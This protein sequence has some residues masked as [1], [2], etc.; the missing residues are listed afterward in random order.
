MGSHVKANNYMIKL[1]AAD[2]TV[3]R[4]YP[5]YV[6]FETPDAVKLPVP[7]RTYLGI[8][9]ACAKV[10]HLSG[11]AEYI[12]RL[13]QDMEGGKILDP[14]GASAYMLEHAIFELQAYGFEITA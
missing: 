8:H 5:E 6:T 1:D 4:D 10:A 12:D 3:L 7:S 9:A 14:N 11:A 13:H 2:Q